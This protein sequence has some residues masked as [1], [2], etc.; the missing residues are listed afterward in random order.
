[1]FKQNKSFISI[2]RTLSL[3]Y[4][5]MIILLS[6]M[7]AGLYFQSVLLAENQIRQ[8]N[9]FL[10][11]EVQESFS[12][13]TEN[14]EKL[15]SHLSYI[16]SSF[17]LS[18]TTKNLDMQKL[19]HELFK[20]DVRSS[21]IPSGIYHDYILDYFILIESPA[22]I[23]NNELSLLL[24][25]YL[26]YDLEF[27]SD[28]MDEVYSFFFNQNIDQGSFSNV[29]SLLR[30]KGEL[31]QPDLT[32]QI[33]IVQQFGGLYSGQYG[34][35]VIYIDEKPLLRT[36]EKIDISD[37]GGVFVLDNDGNIDFGI[38]NG[39]YFESLLNSSVLTDITLNDIHAD[40][41][42]FATEISAS[43][44]QT[45]SYLTVQSR[46]YLQN[47]TKKIRY[48][49]L[50]IITVLLLLGIV[51]SIIVVYLNSKPVNE[52]F[53]E[54]QEKKILDGNDNIKLNLPGG[55][56][57]SFNF[58]VH[59]MSNF[60]DEQTELLEITVMEKLLNGYHIQEEERKEIIEKCLNVQAV[61][62]T[63]LILS[64][65]SNPV[66]SNADEISEIKFWKSQIKMLLDNK[67]H[68]KK[69]YL[70]DRNPNELVL[71]LQEQEHKEDQVKLYA[72]SLYTKISADYFSE[73]MIAVGGSVHSFEDIHYSYE[74]ALLVR[75]AHSLDINCGILWYTDQKE[76][77]ILLYFP[78][79]FE[80]KI[81]N[82]VISGD[83]IT[84]EKI[85][86]E[87]YQ[88]NFVE[89][90]ISFA[91]IRTLLGSMTGVLISLTQRININDH[92]VQSLIE[93]VINKEPTIY[94]YV[95][96]LNQLMNIFTKLVDLKNS[97][98]N[99]R[100]AGIVQDICSYIDNNF[101]NPFLSADHVGSELGI[102]GNYV[103][104][105]FKEYY[106]TSFHKYIERLR[107]DCAKQFLKE[108]QNKTIKE[109]AFES[110]YASI[111]TF[112]KA[113]KK[114]F[115]IS[116]GDYRKSVSKSI[117]NY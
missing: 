98:Q 82:S 101:K 91:L 9:Q 38:A 72:E 18:A 2:F 111:T 95:D 7:G 114:N 43:N 36:L 13:L 22:V 71:I 50:L 109:I 116:A 11:Q 68:S 17:N 75:D 31:D 34:T 83:N 93:G 112:Y 81:I 70:L 87:V 106:G 6:I 1:M 8:K 32:Y 33:G 25:S 39:D 47:Q 42:W 4:L 64:V 48:T 56:F 16:S 90:R 3:P 77:S 27:N 59:K 5:I 23:L 94:N 57:S 52:M 97:I 88:K 92:N 105:L 24:D 41:R 28:E 60:M 44:D 62:F 107:M 12:S 14:T 74:Q 29:I 67:S 80:R 110:G 19:S 58:N 79:D 65:T 10:L 102:T 115:G 108:E 15:F 78:V 66:P 30:Q 63:V 61:K 73:T 45:Y 54:F 86:N 100:K 84:L 51:F 99:D 76:T 21:L 89:N 69:F 20:I 85:L 26:K 35:I 103:F 113:F 49:L 96:Y 37:E 46:E 53:L 40:S 117:P 55:L 104:K